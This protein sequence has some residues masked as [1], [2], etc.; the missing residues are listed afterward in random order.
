M[1]DDRLIARACRA[2]YRELG[3]YCMVLG[4][5]SET[6]LDTLSRTGSRKQGYWCSALVRLLDLL[7][8][9]LPAIEPE[10]LEPVLVMSD[11]LR[12]RLLTTLV[13]LVRQAL[14]REVND[15]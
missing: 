6:Y 14:E 9:S 8:D 2:R 4:L 12:T 15:G 7:A 10:D 3:T 1:T 13:R 5:L 11:Q